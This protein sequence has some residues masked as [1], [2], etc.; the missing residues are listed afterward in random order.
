MSKIEMKR[1]RLGPTTEL[2]KVTENF[3]NLLRNA[4][5]VPENKTG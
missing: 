1:C 4:N 2:Y 3:A 5:I